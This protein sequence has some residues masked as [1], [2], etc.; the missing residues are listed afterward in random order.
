VVAEFEIPVYFL[1]GS[2]DYTCNAA[3]AKDYFEK[4][5]APVK[6]FYIF[7]HS[8]HS[9]VFE[10]P[11][12]ARQILQAD[13]LNGENKLSDENHTEKQDAD[14]SFLISVFLRFHLHLWRQAE[15]SAFPHYIKLN[16]YP[17]I[18]YK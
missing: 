8:A 14:F 15:V 12:K 11:E 9:P 6:G 13:V 10:E 5:N 3:L 7:E 2:H 17:C 16:H 18:R 4:N 1:A